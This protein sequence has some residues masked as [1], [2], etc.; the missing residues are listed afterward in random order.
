MSTQDEA[1]F[2][3]YC[4]ARLAEEAIFCHRCGKHLSSGAPV[5]HEPTVIINNVPCG[6]AKDKWIAF[7]LCLLLGLLGVHKFY[8][9]KIF[10]GMIYLFTFGLLGIG[11]IV[12]LIL[13]LLKPNPYYV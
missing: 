12:D 8:E 3:P 5:S 1:I 4:G 13:L 6:S 9:G 10:F 7:I 2:C 11:V